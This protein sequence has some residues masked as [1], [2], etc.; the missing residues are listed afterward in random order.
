VLL[1]NGKDDELFGFSATA[2]SIAAL[3]GCAIWDPPTSRISRCGRGP[4][5]PGR[6]LLSS[7]IGFD[8]LYAKDNFNYSRPWGAD[9][10]PYLMLAESMPATR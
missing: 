4:H 5:D 9:F 3:T 1:Q 2:P 7:L 10:T 8:S 6:H